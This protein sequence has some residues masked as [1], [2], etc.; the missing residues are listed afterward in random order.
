MKKMKRKKR[1]T[2][3]WQQ[4]RW[5]NKKSRPRPLFPHLQKKYPA[6]CFRR[7]LPKKALVLR[8]KEFINSRLLLARRKYRSSMHFSAITAYIRQKF[9]L[10]TAAVRQCVLA[11]RSACG[12][13]GSAR[14]SPCQ[15]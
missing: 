3:S 9:G 6:F 1:R 2:K 13:I 15:K 4:N 11:A 12:K 10:C 8:Q 5:Q 7:L 14:L